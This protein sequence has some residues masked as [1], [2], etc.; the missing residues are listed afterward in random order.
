MSY[1]VQEGRTE[2]VFMLKPFEITLQ[3]CNYA[4]ESWTIMV[5]NRSYVLF[6]KGQIQF[7]QQ[8]VDNEEA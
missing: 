5:R 4:E 6:Q 8:S 3:K 2:N 1:T 7:I